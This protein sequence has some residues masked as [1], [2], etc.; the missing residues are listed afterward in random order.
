[1]LALHKS[2]TE[3]RH[4]C[5]WRSRGLGSSLTIPMASISVMHFLQTLQ[6][7]LCCPT[8]SS[9]LLTFQHLLIGNCNLSHTL[10]FL[11]DTSS[12]LHQHTFGCSTTPP[13]MVSSSAALAASYISLMLRT[14]QKLLMSWDS[15]ISCIFFKWLF[16]FSKNDA[17]LGKLDLLRYSLCSSSDGTSLYLSFS[18]LQVFGAFLKPQTIVSLKKAVGRSAYISEKAKEMKN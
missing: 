9:A 8:L 10:L 6:G 16:L 4:I 15:S 12:L 1:M 13:L 17:S 18:Q 5:S 11:S 3:D 2:V 14:L 7:P